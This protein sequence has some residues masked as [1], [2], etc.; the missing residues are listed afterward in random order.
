MVDTGAEFASPSGA[1]LGYD[2]GSRVGEVLPG[3]VEPRAPVERISQSSE[4]VATH[5]AR[6]SM[7][8][9]N[10]CMHAVAR[11]PVRGLC[12]EFRC[13]PRRRRS[14]RLS[15]RAEGCGALH[16]ADEVAI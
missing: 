6:M 10:V 16:A 9:H 5:S 12:L 11:R 8:A 1:P 3:P 15:A 7:S 2:S 14:V 4:R 13:D